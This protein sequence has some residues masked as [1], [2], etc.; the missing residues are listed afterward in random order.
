MNLLL[1]LLPMSRLTSHKTR[2]GD[3]TVIFQSHARLGPSKRY[4]GTVF[5]K[6]SSSDTRTPPNSTSQTAAALW[7]VPESVSVTVCIQRVVLQYF[8]CTVS[9]QS[10]AATVALPPSRHWKHFVFLHR[11]VVTLVVCTGPWVGARCLPADSFRVKAGPRR[12]LV[13][14]L[15]PKQPSRLH[16]T[17]P[18]WRH[19]RA[20]AS[21]PCSQQSRVGLVMSHANGLNI[22]LSPRCV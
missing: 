5:F 8:T 17:P 3:R 18:T 22:L 20:R 7:I 6:F 1:E 12:L 21:S 19:T 11:L 10:C 9:P 16:G 13:H 14:S 15:C 4:V 2:P